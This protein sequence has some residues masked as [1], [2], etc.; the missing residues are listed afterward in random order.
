[1][2]RSAGA[3]CGDERGEISEP[4]KITPSRIAAI[5]SAVVVALAMLHIVG[6][7][8]P[9]THEE[10]EF[11][12]PYL[13]VSGP[14]VWMIALKMS[15]LTELAFSPYLQKPLDPVT[16]IVIIP[17]LFNIILGSLQWYLVAALIQR[18]RRTK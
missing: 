9:K 14:L 12:F 15:F 5:Y 2:E 4:M 10:G 13:V 16:W 3:L 18:L 1:M 11:Y 8:V 17:G 7:Y 6:I